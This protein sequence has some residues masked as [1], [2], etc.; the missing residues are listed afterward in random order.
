MREEKLGFG[1]ILRIGVSLLPLL[2]GYSLPAVIWCSFNIAM[3]FIIC[4]PLTSV[5]SSLCAICISMFFCSFFG[6]GAKLEGLFIALQAIFCAAACV[7]TVAG[8]KKFFHG[9]WIASIGYLIPSFL[10]VKNAATAAGMSVA[11]YLT[12]LPFQMTKTE[13]MSS[14]NDPS[15]QMYTNEAAVVLD[16]I[17][18]GLMM[19]V[20]S[21]LIISSVIVGYMIM[22]CVSARL[23]AL[24]IRVE[25]SFSEIKIPRLMILVALISL[26]MSFAPLGGVSAVA[27]NVF[28]VLISFLFFAGIS[29]FEFFMRK[30]IKSGFIRVIIHVA[31]FFSLSAI[32]GAIYVLI[33]IIDAFCD[34]RKIKKRGQVCET[35]E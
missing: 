11:Q 18:T 17:H 34:F 29:F 13:I 16:L 1:I 28:S 14:M 15:L 3:S 27:L 33:A 8:R 32:A 6:E 24:P 19:L 26:A 9:V 23:R 5:V 4:G 10:S 35:E 31:I 20:P 22:W 7:Y 25:H 30:K 21:I 2:F 12:D